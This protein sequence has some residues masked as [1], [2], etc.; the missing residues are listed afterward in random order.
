MTSLFT[1][2]H[3]RSRYTLALL[4]GALDYLA[5]TVTFDSRRALP[6]DLLW[7]TDGHDLARLY[8]NLHPSADRVDL[9]ALLDG[10]KE[11][12]LLIEPTLRPDGL[13]ESDPGYAAQNAKKR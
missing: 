11:S 9:A 13:E 10:L 5:G 2:T 7:Y 3:H 12:A 8:F 1:P 6:E 4:D